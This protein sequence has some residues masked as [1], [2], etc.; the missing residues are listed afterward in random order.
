VNGPLKSDPPVRLIRGDL[1]AG[2][3]VALILIPQAMAYAELAGLAPHHGLYAAAFPPIVAALLASSPYLQTGPVALG[4]LL[5]FGALVPLATPGTAEFAALAALLAL[6]T[7]AARIVVGVTRIGWLVYLMSH[8]M[9]AGFLSAAAILILASQLPAALGVDLPPMDGII[10]RAGFSVFHPGWWS[11]S[12][13]GLSVFTVATVVFCNRFGPLVPGVLIAGVAGL[14]YS[15]VSGYDG[16]VI[17]TVPEGLPPLSLDLPWRAL[18]SLFMPALVIAVIGFADAVSI[19]RL[20]ASEDRQKWDADREFVSKGMADIAAGL[21]SGFPIGGS[22]SRTSMNRSAGAGS[23]WSGLV[24]G[25]AVL[26]FLP[27][28]GVLAPLPKAVLAGMVIAAVASLVRPMRLLSIWKVSR[29]QAVVGW[30]TFVATLYLSPHI[31]QAVVLGVGLSVGV[32]LWRELS[33]R[34]PADRDGDALVVEPSGVL[35]F[36]S[37]PRLEDQLFDRLAE[38]PDVGRVVI[39][40]GGLGRIDLSGAYVL[41][42]TMEQAGRVGLEMTLEDVPAHA[43]RLLLA[44][45]VPIADDGVSPAERRLRRD[46]RTG[47]DRRRP[48]AFPEPEASALRNVEES[49]VLS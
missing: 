26:C 13:V 6:L 11:P 10:E 29:P 18:P 2:V 48:E 31:D 36:G 9:M 34:V 42:E 38:E 27:F 1:I 8:A 28:A 33:P 24:T 22:L 4:A 7:G 12:A 20:Y 43:R 41:A 30:T 47:G 32:H 40:C 3:S 17:G 19:A 16:T 5:T 21:T 46:R 15:I 37:A 39:R 14:L 35:W 44:V 45:G 25:L 49:D 23:R